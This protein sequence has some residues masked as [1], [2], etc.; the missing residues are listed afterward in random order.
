MKKNF[1]GVQM[2]KFLKNSFFTI[3]CFILI[4]GISSSVAAKKNSKSP[5]KP[6]KTK[7]R[8]QWFEKHQQLKDTSTFKNLPWS[9]VGPVWMS[10]RITDI[11]VPKGS[12]HTIIAATASGGVWKTINEGTTWEPIFENGLSTS[13]GDIAISDSDP[14]IL[15]VGTGEKNSSRSS[16]SGAGI[17]KSSDGGK[18]WNHMGLGDTQHISR[19]LIHPQNPDTVYVAAIGNLYTYNPERGVFKTEDG[20]KTWTKIHYINEKTGCIDLVMDPSNPDI[21]LAATW[22]RLRNAWNMQE[23]GPGSAIYK[24]ADEGKNWIK[25]SNGLPSKNEM[26]RVGL[27][28]S[29]SNPNVIYAL[30]DNHESKRKPKPGEL[31]SYGLPAKKIIKGAEVYRSDNKGESWKLVDTKYNMFYLYFEYGYYFGEIRVDPNDENTIYTL[32][33]PLFKS[34]DGGKTYKSIYYKD[35]HGDHQAMWINPKDSNH[36]INGN[37]G[38]VNISYDGG[39][40]WR[41][42]NNIPTIQF[43]NVYLDNQTPFNIYGSVQDHGCFR[44]PVTHNPKRNNAW[45]WVSIPGGEASYIEVDPLNPDILYSEG[46]YGSLMKSNLKDNTRKQI[47]PK[48]EKGKPALRCN[49]LTPFIISP[50]NPMTIFFGSQYLHRSLNSGETWQTISPDLTQNSPKKR[51]DVPFATITTISESPI[52]PGLIYVGTDDGNVQVTKTGGANWQKITKTLPK[53]K[54]ISR[55]FAS[56]HQKGT[57]YL[58][59]NGYRND[60]FNAY[61]YKS[62]N[63]GKNWININNNLPGGPVNVIKEDPKN[64]NILY[65]GTD[66]G[67]YI[68][69]DKGISWNSISNNLPTTFV[70]DL[71]VHSRD[72]I[73]VIATHGRGI[74]VM[75]VSP[76]Q[77]YTKDIQTKDLH[78]FKMA[79]IKLPRSW[80]DPRTPLPIIYTLKQDQQEKV[81]ISI[82]DSQNKLVKKLSHTGT[83]GFNHLQWNLDTE[84]KKEGKGYAKAGIYTIELKAGTT[85]VKQKVEFK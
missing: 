53:N 72:N 24:T 81:E 76:I 7:I 18:T 5:S 52:V 10:G 45:D 43:Y 20:G 61:I 74:Y 19:I 34:T 35:L 73:L 47:R 82:F 70:H 39:K 12:K 54:W 67:I 2:Y 15:W 9:F 25:L 22:D 11:E 32:G 51:G 42:I 80:W 59:L 63:F 85:T 17:Y 4:M 58:S 6:T 23:A 38:G 56:A 64:E 29:Q 57:I 66:I 36:I 37:D 26:G 83:A 77:S 60:D 62:T 78:L 46:Y 41:D 48:A 3:A 30:I 28:I 33:I 50:H 55:V 75:D 1:K 13:I 79:P 44:G 21:L 84:S 69:L 49:W 65:V 71:S 68:S 14:N 40:T 27:S 31:D 16:Y 8:L